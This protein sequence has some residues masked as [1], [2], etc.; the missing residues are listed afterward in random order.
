MT[1]LE[2]IGAAASRLAQFGESCRDREA[3]TVT[4]DAVTAIRAALR[5]IEHAA[6]QAERKKPRNF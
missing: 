2:K 4:G 6:E 5:E 1:P 3:R